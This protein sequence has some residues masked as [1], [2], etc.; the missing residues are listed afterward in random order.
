MPDIKLSSELG[1]VSLLSDGF[2]SFYT[3]VVTGPCDRK[4]QTTSQGA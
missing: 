2:Q 4:N 3:M 1:K